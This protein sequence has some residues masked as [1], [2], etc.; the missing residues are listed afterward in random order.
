MNN[1][2]FTLRD[3]SEPWPHR[4]VSA[5]L[6]SP[7]FFQPFAV[8]LVV[9]TAVYFVAKPALSHFLC[10]P[11]ETIST[12]Q[13]AWILTLYSAILMLSFGGP[14]VIE[15]ATL[16]A[17]ATV[18]DMPSLD[19]DYSWGLGAFFFAYLVADTVIGVI[20]YPTQFSLLSGW[21]HHI[22]YALVVITQMQYGQIGGYLTMASVMELSTVFLSMGHLNKLWRR[23]L[24]FGAT[25]PNELVQA[26]LRNLPID[27]QLTQLGLVSKRLF[28]PSVFHDLASARLHFRTLLLDSREPSI[29]AFLNSRNLKNVGWRTLPLNYQTVIFGEILA[30]DE[31]GQIQTWVL[32]DMTNNL[33]WYKRWELSACQQN[34]PVRFMARMGYLDAVK[35]L[36]SADSMVDLGDQEN[37]A[38]FCVAANG[39]LPML[40]FLLSCPKVNPSAQDNRAI[41]SAVQSG[42]ISCVARL[43]QDPRVDPSPR[44]DMCFR[45]ACD[46]GDTEMVHLL[47]ADPRVSPQVQ[48]N[49]SFLRACERGWV[50]IVRT[51]LRDPR[52]DP[53]AR[54]NSAIRKAARCGHTQIVELLLENDRVDPSAFNNSALLGACT[55][56]RVEVV[57]LLLGHAHPGIN[58]ATNLQSPLRLAASNGHVEVVRLLL[59][60]HEVDPSVMEN[61]ALLQA[62]ENGY[63]DVVRLLLTDERVREEV[64]MLYVDELAIYFPEPEYD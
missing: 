56:G 10:K 3:P 28:A 54:S 60:F 16:P 11:N 49:I 19:S 27:A 37:L 18:A 2:N 31:W 58:P 64:D 6:T 41:V 57:K 30:A 25:L 32:D 43:L 33:M 40:D 22:G 39:D 5:V 42:H 7:R 8:G 12:R 55:F 4:S 21:I 17:K 46:R 63:V 44:Q 14:L 62:H 34:R 45:I 35:L 23:D 9:A 48:Q 26:I 53:G 59:G 38:V 20:D 1:I 51:L 36:V 13:R 24:W 61:E 47:L 52:V 50:E 29:W 15:F